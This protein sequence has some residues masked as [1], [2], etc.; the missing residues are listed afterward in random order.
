MATNST[1]FTNTPQAKDDGYSWSED[2]LLASALFNG[3]AVTLGAMTNDLGGNAKSLYSV[4]DGNGNTL[5]PD[6][7]LLN[8]DVTNGVSAW[9]KTAAGNWIRINNGNIEFKLDGSLS[10][11]GATNVNALALGDQI[12]D[13]F[14]YAIRLGN[15]TLSQAR[16][17]INI[18]G[19]NDGPVANAD[20]ASATEAGGVTNGSPGVNP[21]GN[22]LT[23]DTDVDHVDTQTVTTTGVFTGIYGELTL[24]ADGTYNYVL[25][26]ANVTVQALRTGSDTLTD[27]FS[28]TMKDTAG[29][30]STATLTVTVHGANDAPVA[31]A[32]TNAGDAVTEAGVNPGNT[33]FAGDTSAAG[34]VLANDTDVDHGDTKTVTTT[35]DFTG[36]YGKLTLNANGSYTYTL[37]NVRTAT[38]ALAHGEQSSDTFSYTVADA[39]GATA[40]S[41]LTITIAG[42]NDSP[43]ITTALGGNAGTVV[44][45]G[46]LDDGAVVAGDPEAGGTLTSSDVDNGATATWSGSAAGTYGSFAINAGGAWTY[47][48]NN[49]AADTDALAEGA[50]VTDRFTATVTDDKGATATQSVTIAI[51]GTNDSPVAV[52]DTNAGDAVVESGINPG[53]TAY[54]GDT[55]AAGNLLTNDTDV[56]TD[57]TKSVSAVNG[58]AGNVGTAIVGTYGTATISSN[59]GYTYTLN[60]ADSDTNALAQGASASDVF[61]YTVKDDFGAVSSSTLTIAISGTNDAPVVAAADVSGAVTE[62]ATASGN[63]TDSG[64]IGFTDVDLTDIHSL[65]AIAPSSGALGTL[66]ASVSSDTTG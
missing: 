19:N 26:N 59:G 38:E 23:N 56:D 6:F 53:N 48:L 66:T 57:A 52:A 11:L 63:L 43:V 61:S 34:N 29:A 45:A 37:D 22:V 25:D 54:A 27:T 39:A 7:D 4:D 49:A 2:G 18:S 13:E 20:T 62:Q 32:D 47:T 60:N 30:T 8:S 64:A 31:F 41:N 5:V 14:V 40:T 42:T 15:G 55:T 51:A 65:S 3:S 12:R 17:A 58:V 35:G 36:S 24:N 9:E 50:S 1:A 16:I 21:V 33:A 46:N 28:Y 44:E 10:S